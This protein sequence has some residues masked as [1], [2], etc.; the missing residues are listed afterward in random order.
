[1]EVD[2]L[3]KRGVVKEGMI[4]KLKSGVEVI[5]KGVG[6]V[7]IIKGTDENSIIEEILSAEGVGTQ[8]IRRRR[9]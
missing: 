9:R 8:I 1:M 6:K 5:R 7:H 4:P 3:I 2:G